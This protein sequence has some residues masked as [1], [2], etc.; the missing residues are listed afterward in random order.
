MSAQWGIER[1]DVCSWWLKA[2]ALEADNS[3]SC[4]TFG[5]I[6]STSDA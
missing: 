1:P 4:I 2:F 5:G 6:E 3:F